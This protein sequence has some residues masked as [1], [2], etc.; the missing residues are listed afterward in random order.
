MQFQNHLVGVGRTVGLVKR[1]KDH[2]LLH[3]RERQDLL[4]LEAAVR[5][6]LHEAIQ[7]AQRCESGGEIRQRTRRRRTA[8]FRHHLGHRS[9]KRRDQ[10]RALGRIPRG[11]MK[12][13]TRPQLAPG[14][15]GHHVE[16]EGRPEVRRHGIARRFV[17]HAA[18][19]RTRGGSKDSE[20]VETHPW[21]TGRIHFFADVRRLGNARAKVAADTVADTT[22][23]HRAQSILR[24]TNPLRPGSG[25]GQQKWPHAGEPANGRTHVERSHAAFASMPFHREGDRLAA[26]AVGP[27]LAKSRQ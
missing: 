4:H 18:E 16:V 6:A 23:G 21:R 11:A 5:A 20:I 25:P 8:A 17:H 13:K 19:E 2:A 15:F 1:V 24:R 10:A 9:L 26:A 12:M 22:F 27:S 14:H 3:R 7:F